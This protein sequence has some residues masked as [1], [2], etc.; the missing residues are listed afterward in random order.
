M[1]L[2]LIY[3]YI[4]PKA[5]LKRKKI[6]AKMLTFYFEIYRCVVQILLSVFVKLHCSLS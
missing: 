4:Y 2:Q 5:F 3:D 1:S 6:F